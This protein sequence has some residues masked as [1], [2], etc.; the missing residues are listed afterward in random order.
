MHTLKAGA[1]AATVHRPSS[2]V[3]RTRGFLLTAL[4]RGV[5]CPVLSTEGTDIR[6]NRKET[7]WCK[8]SQEHQA[9]CFYCSGLSNISRL[10]SESVLPTSSGFLPRAKQGLAFGFC[11]SGFNDRAGHS[12]AFH[13]SERTEMPQGAACGYSLWP[14]SRCFS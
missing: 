1:A 6:C 13:E 12:K 9:F 11:F 5:E 2:S 14:A 10:W 4:K 8:G 7:L 3:L